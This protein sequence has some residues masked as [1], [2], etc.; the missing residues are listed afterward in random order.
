MWLRF[1][2]IVWNCSD[3]EMLGEGLEEVLVD[4]WDGLEWL[5]CVVK[6]VAEK[7]LRRVPILCSFVSRWGGGGR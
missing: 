5:G 1:D 2:E 3:A 7:R 4:A 6:G